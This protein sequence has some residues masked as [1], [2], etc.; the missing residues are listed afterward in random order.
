MKSLFL[1]IILFYS[2]IASQVIGQ[3]DSLFDEGVNALAEDNYKKAAEYFEKDIKQAPNFEGF[4][5]LGIAKAELGKSIESLWAFESAL[6]YK[7]INGSAQFNAA[8][9]FE[10][11]EPS[12]EWKHPFSWYTRIISS[13]NLMLW[14]SIAFIF[15][16]VSGVII[17]LIASKH[18]NFGLQ[19][20]SKRLIIPSILILAISIYGAIESSKHFNK[21]HFLYPKSENITVYIKPGGIEL[22]DKLSFSTRYKIISKEGEWLEVKTN[23]NHS[24]WT[25]KEDVLSY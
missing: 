6:K 5:N 17:Y 23:K 24:V 14:I 8:L 12:K 2:F 18:Q 21:L 10:E 4:Y 25:K 9:V 13:V 22:K 3:T 19:K 11:I 20:W 1:F 7:P 16:L 15:S